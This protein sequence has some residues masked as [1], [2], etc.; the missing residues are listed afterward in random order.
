VGIEA[1]AALEL[2]HERA[3]RSEFLEVVSELREVLGSRLVAYLGEA[4]GTSA[5]DGWA[6]GKFEPAGAVQARLRL[7]LEAAL[8]IEAVDGRR[9]A[10][11]WLQGMNPDLGDRSPADVLREGQPEADGVAVLGA[12]RAFVAA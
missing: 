6:D 7:A 12:A 2:A 9:V 5:V 10:R 4:Q 11:A 8:T 3:M 1:R